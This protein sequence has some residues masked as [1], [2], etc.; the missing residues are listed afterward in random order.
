MPLSSTPNTNL[1]SQGTISVLLWLLAKSGLLTAVNMI[2]TAAVAS[3]III[4]VVLW[5]K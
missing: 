3:K 1:I 2:K 4:L 5:R